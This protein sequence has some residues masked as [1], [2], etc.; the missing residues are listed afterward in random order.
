MVVPMTATDD[1]RSKMPDHLVPHFDALLKLYKH[2]A[3]LHVGIKIAHPAVLGGLVRD[4]WRDIDLFLDHL[5]EQ[6]KRRGQV[7][8]EL[9]TPI[10]MIPVS[11]VLNLARAIANGEGSE[12]GKRIKDD[13]DLESLVDP[14]RCP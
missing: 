4:G 10:A 13:V 5:E 11:E 9:R 2:H 1:Q 3:Q 6:V 7:V 8:K 12:T 14:N